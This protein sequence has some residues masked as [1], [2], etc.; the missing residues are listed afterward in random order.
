MELAAVR[1]SLDRDNVC[2]IHLHRE[3][4]ARSD[5]V[6]VHHDRTDAADAMLA[7]YMCSGQI[8]VLAQKVGQQSAWLA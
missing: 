2:S 8:E 5:R 4:K 6:A 7:A 1:N 3:H